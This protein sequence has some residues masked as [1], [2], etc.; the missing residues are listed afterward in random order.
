[1]KA[2]DFMPGMTVPL[3]KDQDEFFT[4]PAIKVVYDDGVEAFVT[5]WKPTLVDRLRFLIGK[6]LYLLLLTK[7]HPPTLLTT[8]EDEVGLD[9]F[10]KEE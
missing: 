2:F 5:G 7:Q 1:M 3:G 4:L 8:D 10:Y 9:T 6:P